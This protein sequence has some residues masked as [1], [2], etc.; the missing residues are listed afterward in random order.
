MVVK[1]AELPDG[2]AVATVQTEM[3]GRLTV[4]TPPSGMPPGEGPPWLRMPVEKQI[5]AARTVLGLRVRVLDGPHSELCAVEGCPEQLDSQAAWWLFGGDHGSW[6]GRA[7]PVFSASLVREAARVGRLQPND[8]NRQPS[9]PFSA[10]PDAT[11]TPTRRRESRAGIG[12]Q[13]RQ[14]TVWLAQGLMYESIADAARRSDNDDFTTPD[15]ST[16]GIEQVDAYLADAAGRALRGED[17]P[18]VRWRGVVVTFDPL[19]EH[20]V[21]MRLSADDVTHVWIPLPTSWI[22][23]PGAGRIRQAIGETIDTADARAT[24]LIAAANELADRIGTPLERPLVGAPS[25]AASESGV[26]RAPTSSTAAV[27][28]LRPPHAPAG[29]VDSPWPPSA[30]PALQPSATPGNHR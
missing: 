7:R 28:F 26:G 3:D 20:T 2:P 18:A 27:A 19:D 21:Q 10:A 30:V 6:E 25:V 11:Q 22:S 15:G 29:S 23:D 4:L 24:R 13:R 1:L 16:V 8:E 12:R 17:L 14:V 9:E 5:L